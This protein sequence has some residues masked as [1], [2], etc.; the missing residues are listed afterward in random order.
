MTTYQIRYAFT[1]VGFYIV[2]AISG[3]AAGQKILCYP[4]KFRRIA[5]VSNRAVLGCVDVTADQLRELGF[6]LP[7]IRITPYCA[8]YGYL[9]VKIKFV[10]NDDGTFNVTSLH[11][12]QTVVVF[13]AQM[14]RRLSINPK[15]SEGI[16]EIT[17]YQAEQVGLKIK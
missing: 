12:K 7:A 6:V 9:T 8:R 16:A 5:G 15:N 14:R 3:P 13:P 2:S 1:P 10:R 4:K 17:A 11:N